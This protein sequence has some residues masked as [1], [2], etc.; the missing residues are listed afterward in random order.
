MR[1]WPVF[2]FSPFYTNVMYKFDF[3]FQ[4]ST[5]KNT[6]LKSV[7]SLWWPVGPSI[8]NS[9]AFWEQWRVTHH[10]CFFFFFFLDQTY[11]CYFK[12]NVK[13]EK[14]PVLSREDRVNATVVSKSVNLI[15][16]A[17][18]LCPSY[19]RTLWQ[20]EGFEPLLFCWS[21]CR[22]QHIFLPQFIYLPCQRQ[23]KCQWIYPPPPR[24]PLP[25][26]CTLGVT[27]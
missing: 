17:L 16:A 15:I 18:S 22:C 26:T 14:Y 13:K 9:H 5:E 7:G 11:I 12:T 3:I 1:V 27:L 25:P 23:V 2:F 4:D 21:F 8:K 24:P 20:F 10:S 6:L 19:S